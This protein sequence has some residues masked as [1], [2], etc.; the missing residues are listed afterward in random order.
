MPIIT[1]NHKD[2]FRNPTTENKLTLL[3]LLLDANELSVNL[4][5]AL[6]KVIHRELKSDQNRDRSLFKRYAQ[7]IEYLHY[8]ML[9]TLQLVVAAWKYNQA[10]FTMPTEWFPDEDSNDQQEKA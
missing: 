2:L 1:S 5:L 8:H 3:Q 9:D 6:L 4:T 10:P 7:T